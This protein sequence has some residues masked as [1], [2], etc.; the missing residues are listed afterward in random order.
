MLDL[1]SLYGLTVQK[2]IIICAVIV[3]I[4]ILIL[5]V[6]RIFR[7]PFQYPYFTHEFD[8]SGKR[9]PE[10]AD[11]IDNYINEGN[12][13]RLIEHRDL[14]EHWKNLCQKKIDR[15]MIK[16]IRTKQFKKCMDDDNMFRF[17]LVRDKTR[18]RQIYYKRY[19]YSYKDAA[20]VYTF[21][22]LYL[23][24]RYKRLKDIGFECTLR[25]YNNNTQ[26]LLL[27][28]ALRKQIMQRDNYT[29]KLCGKYMP[30]EVGLQ[31]DHIIP[32]N[33][34]GKTVPSN[35][36]VLCSKCNGM[37]GSRIYNS[38]DHKPIIGTK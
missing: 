29:C 34:G 35:L 18:Y 33:K 10:I 12:I 11:L 4:I 25:E 32:I 36:Q 26:R 14:V 20:E 23:L 7:S 21:P 24:D 17:V 9:N 38:S 28:K 37:K 2:L 30:D 31:I 27:T 16:S 1:L 3:G 15:S 6:R 22:F 13:Q 19:S 8:I 5:I